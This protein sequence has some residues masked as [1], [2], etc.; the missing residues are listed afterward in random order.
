MKPNTNNHITMNIITFRTRLQSNSLR[1]YNV[2]FALLTTSF[3]ISSILV[4][5]S[6][7]ADSPAPTAYMRLDPNEIYEGEST[8]LTVSVI[9]MTLDEDPN[10]SALESDFAVVPLGPSTRTSIRSYFNGS[11]EQRVETLTT[12]YRYQLTPKKTGNVTIK[13]PG[14]LVDSAQVEAAPITLTVKESTQTDLVILE[15]SASPTSVYPLVPFEVSIDVLVKEA[16]EK[17]QS[18]NLLDIIANNLGAPKLTIPWLQSRAIAS[19]VIEEADLEEWLNEIS[20]KNYGFALNNFQLSRDFFDFGFSMFD[21]RRQIAMFL[22]QAKSEERINNVGEKVKYQKYSF[23]RKMRG[24]KPIKLDFSPASLKGY[25]IDFTDISEPKQQS[26]FLSSQPVS[27]TVKAIPEEEAPD[28]YVGIYG[29]VK[30]NVEISSDDVAVGDAFTLTIAFQGYG[31]F[32]GAVAPDLIGIFPPEEFK[33]YK[34]TERSLENGV[35]FDYIIRPIIQGNTVIPSIKTSFFNVELG[36]FVEEESQPI[37]IAIRKSLLTKDD[38]VSNAPSRD[39]SIAPNSQ[40]TSSIEKQKAKTNRFLVL[41]L[42]IVLFVF[43]IYFV[44]L[45]SRKLLSIYNIRLEASNKRIR[46]AAQSA[47]NEG[48]EIIKDSPSEGIKFLRIAFI[49]LIGKRFTQTVEALTD[50]EIIA[51][52]DKELNEKKQASRLFKLEKLDEDSQKEVINILQKLKIFFQKAEK[53]R[54]GGGAIT[55]ENFNFSVKNLFQDWIKLLSRHYK[56]LSNIA[57]VSK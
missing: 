19:N 46:E 41:T 44:F 6:V 22:P 14:M 31:S 52:F 42:I 11:Q 9:N 36:K 3:V 20:N 39:S 34:A 2:L 48:L 35:A 55:D 4:P 30:Q 50:A 26:V 8:L 33:L 32:E 10:V 21:D 51:F 15:M 49:Q 56:K 53:I 23:K 37:N 16:P 29:N 43:S 1:V 40:T 27:V 24:T 13:A 12:D 57:I 54:F 25:F 18:R 5:T 47:L 17:Y 38:S 7:L 45:I 28:N